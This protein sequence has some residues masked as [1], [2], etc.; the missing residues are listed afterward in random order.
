MT[1]QIRRHTTSGSL[2][3]TALAPAEG[4]KRRSLVATAATAVAAVAIAATP[5][6][7]HDKCDS[8]ANATTAGGIF[9]PP[10]AGFQIGYYVAKFVD[11]LDEEGIAGPDIINCGGPIE[12][13]RDEYAKLTGNS[14]PNEFFYPYWQATG[15]FIEASRDFNV[16]KAEWNRLREQVRSAKMDGLYGIA[17]ELQIKVDEAHATTMSRFTDYESA[18]DAYAIAIADAA[19]TYRSRKLNFVPPLTVSRVV[20]IMQSS[21]QGNVPEFE[22]RYWID[23]ACVPPALING[24]GL[25]APADRFVNDDVPP[26]TFMDENTLQSP[27]SMLEAVAMTLAT[28]VKANLGRLLPDDF[29]ENAELPVPCA[30]DLNDD[31]IV[32]SNDLGVMLGFWGNCL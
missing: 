3:R 17:A 26:G 21:L 2:L 19:A 20:K 30:G 18:H 10:V 25:L 4:A 12:L 29:A 24:D 23:V 22:V 8:L 6:A 7:A 27:A 28:D 15:A 5:A 31:G 16:S 9:W 1:I 32:D 13:S 11:E 14:D